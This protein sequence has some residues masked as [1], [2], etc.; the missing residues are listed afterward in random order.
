MQGFVLL[1]I[2]ATALSI[3]P[4]N[5][6]NKHPSLENNKQS[7]EEASSEELSSEEASSEEESK[8]NEIGYSAGDGGFN[9]YNY[10][11][12]RILFLVA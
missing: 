1:I 10:P 4:V 11:K 2:A 6:G 8:S 12:P 7:S 5:S 9:G 3:F